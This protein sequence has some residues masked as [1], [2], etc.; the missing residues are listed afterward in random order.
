[1]TW[2]Y[3]LRLLY[4]PYSPLFFS[5][6]LFHHSDFAISLKVSSSGVKPQWFLSFEV[7]SSSTALKC[8]FVSI[9]SRVTGCA[10]LTL[11]H[12]CPPRYRCSSPSSS[13]FHLDYGSSLR[14]VDCLFS[15]TNPWFQQRSRSASVVWTTVV[16]LGCTL[17][18]YNRGYVP[19]SS[20][21]SVRPVC[22]SLGGTISSTPS[23][24]SPTCPSPSRLLN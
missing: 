22:A 2:T 6:S 7:H 8:R 14:S 24:V 12:N 19:P 21:L 4:V 13:P 3:L 23:S 11:G 20:T 15:R 18:D 5:V 1:M 17:L 16:I 10:D 9:F